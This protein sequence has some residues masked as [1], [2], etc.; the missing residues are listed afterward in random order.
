MYLRES[1]LTDSIALVNGGSTEITDVWLVS[2][3]NAVDAG[4]I[5]QTLNYGSEIDPLYLSNCRSGGLYETYWQDYITDLYS[6]S[7]RVYRFSAICS[8]EHYVTTQDE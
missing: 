5:T 7:R 4:D 1:A 6:T 8:F 3:C 2:N